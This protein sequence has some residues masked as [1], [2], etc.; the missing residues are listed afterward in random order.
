MFS[1]AVYRN[2]VCGCYGNQIYKWNN[3]IF[4]LLYKWSN[5]N[6]ISIL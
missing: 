2:M 4:N 5:F 6:K 3:S 1:D